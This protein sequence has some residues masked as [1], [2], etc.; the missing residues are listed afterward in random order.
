MGLIVHYISL[1]ALLGCVA[2]LT[3]NPDW[4]PAVATLGALGV[5]L[6]PETYFARSTKPE[7]KI[8]SQI[9][10]FD[11]TSSAFFHIKEQIDKGTLK[12]SSAELIQHSS[13]RS[14][15][16]ILSLARI[17][18]NFNVYLQDVHTVSKLMSQ[19][20]VSR[21]EERIYRFPHAL[22]SKDYKGKFELFLYQT[23]ASLNGIKLK[24]HDDKK[25]LALSWYIYSHDGELED[26]TQ[27][28][29]TGGENPCFVIN[30]DHSQFVY[31][32]KFFD[33]Q[34]AS[35]LTQSLAPI[36]SMSNGQIL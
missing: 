21:V 25:I 10:T 3:K 15:D 32:E 16:L 31:F 23:P 33:L 29:I 8:L 30:S 19:R 28:T 7:D 1:F 36:I 27:C 35:Y 5:F 2:W 14:H 34:L 11:S 26:L 17:D 6:G 20:Y 13:E 9:K 12:V 4:E 24:T 18:V 22:K